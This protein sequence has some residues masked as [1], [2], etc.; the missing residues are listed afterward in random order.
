M[1][2]GGVWANCGAVQKYDA[3]RV[4]GACMRAVESNSSDTGVTAR[5]AMRISRLVELSFAPG[6]VA[7]A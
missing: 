6:T 2:Y 7:G 1:P 3:D 5:V 4:A